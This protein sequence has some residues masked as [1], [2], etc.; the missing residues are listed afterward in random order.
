MLF[1]LIIVTL[2]A[3]VALIIAWP[4]LW[5]RPGDA[6]AASADAGAGVQ[7]VFKDQLAEIDADLARGM[8]GEADAEAA[9]IELSRRLLAHAATRTEPTAAGMRALPL[10]LRA[11]IAA[12]I[13]V[14]ALALYAGLGAPGL[15]GRPSAA[16]QVQDA[17][18]AKPGEPDI[19]QL[20]AKVE[21]RLRQNPEDARGWDVIAPVY[22]RAQRYEEARAAFARAIAALGETPKRLGGFAESAIRAKDGIVTD[23]ARAAFEKVLKIEPNQVEARFWLALARE[24]RGELKQAAEEYRGLL[25]VAPP[26]APWRGAVA[27]RLA[28]V[29]AASGEVAPSK[30]PTAGDVAAAAEMAPEAR[31]QMIAGM[32]GNLHARLKADGRDAAGWQRLLRAYAIL[33]DLPQ[34]NAALGEARRAL[35]EDK[36]GLSAVDAL[37]KEMGLGS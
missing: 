29:A 3:A 19:D 15:P 12:V 35:A 24:Q 9:R 23:E 11:G 37:A 4:L 28:A 27:E 14:L 26:D 33:G 6:R 31:Q 5:P 17:R 34:A 32:V 16:T 1:W 25:A 10:T 7:A 22:L 30:G 2:T 21:E 20:V 8:I 18:K 36:A 13:P